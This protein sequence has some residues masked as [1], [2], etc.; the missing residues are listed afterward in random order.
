MEKD[1]GSGTLPGGEPPGYDS[2]SSCLHRMEDKCE[3]T[4][5]L[6]KTSLKVSL[7]LGVRPL[8]WALSPFVVLKLNLEPPPSVRQRDSMAAP[9]WQAVKA[10]PLRDLS[11][12]LRT[13]LK[14]LDWTSF[15]AAAKPARAAMQASENFMMGGCLV[16]TGCRCWSRER[17][18]NE[19]GGDGMLVVE[20]E[21][22]DGG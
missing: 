6:P 4:R 7:P 19:A 2:M 21:G 3:R 18:M 22:E 5:I 10:W 20:Q 12:E 11:S 1:M 8:T 15:W 16:V 17:G 14:D 13:S 9:V